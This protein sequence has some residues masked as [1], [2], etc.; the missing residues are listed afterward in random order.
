MILTVTKIKS[1]SN[2]PSLNILFMLNAKHN[3]IFVAE[4]FVLLSEMN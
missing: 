2:I 1:D 4:L 3:V